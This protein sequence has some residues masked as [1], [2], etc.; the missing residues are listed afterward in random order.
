MTL[1]IVHALPFSFTHELRS[2]EKLGSIK[3]GFEETCSYCSM[4]MFSILGMAITFVLEYDVVMTLTSDQVLKSTPSFSTKMYLRLATYDQYVRN[5]VIIFYRQC[6]TVTTIYQ[7]FCYI[8]AIEL[9]GAHQPRCIS[10]VISNDMGCT[11]YLW[12]FNFVVCN[13]LLI[14]SLKFIHYF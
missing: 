12:Q 2:W 6:A 14:Y 3:N 13:Y 8:S 9:V 10:L 4:V 11:Y 1:K 5:H 7:V